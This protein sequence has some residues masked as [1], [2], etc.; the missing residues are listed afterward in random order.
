M[1]IFNFRFSLKEALIVFMSLYSIVF[2][3]LFLMAGPNE[4]FDYQ[5]LLLSL[6]ILFFLILIIKFSREHIFVQSALM[7]GFFLIYIFPRLMMYLI[8][9][10]MIIFPYESVLNAHQI[11]T[12]LLYIL[13]GSMFIYAG[14][15]AAKNIFR[16]FIAPASSYAEP[17]VYNPMVILVIF[18]ISTISVWYV[19]EVMGVSHLAMTGEHNV[20]AQLILVIFNI[21][22]VLF[23]GC[24]TLLIRKFIDKKSIFFIVLIAVIYYSFFTFN[25]SRGV[26]LRIETMIIIILLCKIGDFKISKKYA[27]IFFLFLLLSYCLF[28]FATKNR[29]TTLAKT[30]KAVRDSGVTFWTVSPTITQNRMITQN[31]IKKVSVKKKVVRARGVTL[32]TASSTI[33]QNQNTINKVSLNNK[34]VMG[35]RSMILLSSVMKRI[36]LIDNAI[37]ILSIPAEPSAKSRYMNMSYAGKNIVN[38]ILPGV[39]FKDAEISTSR[40]I[41]VLYRAFSDDYLKAGG[42]YSDFYTAWGIFFLIFGWWTGWFM[43]LVAGTVVHFAYLLIM[44]FGGKYRYHMGALCLLIVSYALYLNMGIDHWISTSVM[45]LGSGVIALILFKLGEF[46]LD[47]TRLFLKQLFTPLL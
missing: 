17:A 10:E 14:F 21:D 2:V 39:V 18:L 6:S 36:G 20:L 26:A 44:R 11:N 28:P 27:L 35:K 38:L 12:S 37:M 22:T 24:A 31:R 3:M 4:I 33:T 19:Q 15:F 45:I 8:L 9:P 47:R 13:V 23:M 32:S 41:P 40:V 34:A 46:I 16:L 30:N 29:I 25:G 7:A 1:K 43:L 5:T 42:Y